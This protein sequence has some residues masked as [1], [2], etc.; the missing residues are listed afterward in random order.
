MR[1]SIMLTMKKKIVIIGAGPGGCC[2]AMMLA[3][4]GFDVTVLEKQSQVGGRNAELKVGDFSFDTGPTFLH[5]PWIIEELFAQADENM[6]DYLTLQKLSPFNKIVYKDKD[7]CCYSDPQR[8]EAEIARV[9]PGNEHK[10]REYLKKERKLNKSLMGCLDLPY[11]HWWQFLR[12][13]VLKAAP[14]VFRPDSVYSKLKKFFDHDYLRMAMSFQTKYL[15]MTPWKCP[16]FLSI[17]ASWEYLY[18]V[19]HVEGG[20]CKISQAFAKAAQKKGARF[21]FNAEVEEC[22]LDGKTITQIQTKEGDTYSCDEVVMNADFA[23]AMTK[24]MGEKNISEQ[25][26]K[27]QPMSCS[28]FM[29]Y[30]GMDKEYPEEPHHQILMADDYKTWTNIIDA[31]K[32]IPDDMAVYVRNSCVTDS[33]VAPKGKCGLYLLVPVPN[34]KEQHDWEIL[35][36]KYKEK[37]IDRV[38]ERTGMKDLREHIEVERI[39]TPQDWDQEINVFLGA[40]FSLKHT[41]DNM[42]YFRPHNK[43]ETFTN[44]YLTGGGTHPGSG[45]IPIL[46]SARISTG[47]LCKKYN[48]PFACVDLHSDK[49]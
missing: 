10:F 19:Y 34:N 38:I 43:Y 18:G 29:I 47:L 5:M 36:P 11:Q 30:L 40:T 32:E 35:T 28:T 33:T 3:H 21:I 9:F 42:L 39:I 12:P 31:N 13:S 16:G 4:K 45:I 8:M 15:G 20:L 48:I 2:A 25:Q 17:L 37:V 46:Q 23:Y 1:W 14:Y 6:K 22:I 7:I 26:M 27:K 44:C 49:L 41:L 24:L